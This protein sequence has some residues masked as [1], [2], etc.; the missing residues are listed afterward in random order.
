MFL[1]DTNAVIGLLY[2]PEII[3]E[4]AHRT[5]TNHADELY[6]SLVTPWEI[7]IKRSLGK[8]FTTPDGED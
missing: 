8:I 7:T 5:M 3:S 4:E 1:L 2:S 6:V